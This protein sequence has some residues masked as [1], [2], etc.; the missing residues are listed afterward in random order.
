MNL[1]D[2]VY[3]WGAGTMILHIA[4]DGIDGLGKTTQIK[5]LKEF[6]TKKSYNVKTLLPI[7]DKTILLY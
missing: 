7:Q 4:L 1:I 3:L 6:L 2:L 5:K